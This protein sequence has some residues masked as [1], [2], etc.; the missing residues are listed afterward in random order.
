MTIIQKFT[1]SAKEFVLRF[2]LQVILSAAIA[3]V[4]IY[5]VNSSNYFPELQKTLGIIGGLSVAFSWSL[6]VNLLAERHQLSRRNSFFVQLIPIAVAAI[7]FW[8][9]SEE[10]FYIN[11]FNLRV[12]VVAV[13]GIIFAITI[14]FITTKR[15]DVWDVF[16]LIV[17]RLVISVLFGA[18]LYVGLAICLSAYGLLISHINGHIFGYLAASIGA[19][20]IPTYFLFGMP[21]VWEQVEFDYTK[22]E[23]I[24]IGTILFPVFLCSYIILYIYLA[25][26]VATW[27][28]PNG[29]VAS[30]IV[31]FSVFGTVVAVMG[32]RIF[33]ESESKL[34][35][36][37]PRIFQIATLPM[38]VVLAIAIKFRVAEY[39]LTASRYAVIAF[40][41]WL[42]IT[43]IYNSLK[44]EIRLKFML[45]FAGC[46]A[47]FA[48]VG[49]YNMATTSVK[50]QYQRAILLFEKHKIVQRGIFVELTA[51]DTFSAE[52]IKQLRSQLDYVLENGGRH[53]F[54]DAM[55]HVRQDDIPRTVDDMLAWY[56]IEVDSDMITSIQSD[57]YLPGDTVLDIS[58]FD[59]MTELNSYIFA[60]D[61]VIKK[62][63]P[64]GALTV[65]NIGQQVLVEIDGHKINLSYEKIVDDTLKKSSHLVPY[66]DLTIEGWS[67]GY[68]AKIIITNLDFEPVGGGLRKFKNMTAVLLLKKDQ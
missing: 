17:R 30:W 1:E 25:K 15:S 41:V 57:M 19:F 42:L 32:R 46:I 45:I 23:R 36:L 7:A 13:V 55:P 52:E 28:W 64:I 59:Y 20:F 67:E 35:Q 9:F 24:L 39:G 16:G 61:G 22:F 40:G 5:M 4:L 33:A 47:L 34:V 27:E 48:A 50:N 29:E 18:V 2:G 44:K 54:F 10:L 12:G 8:N 68:R 58:G 38:I 31:G 6:F 60:V 53:L 37:F 21:K 63:T 66:T 51:A 3:G 11:I 62:N 49:P 65:S 43:A 26:I 56:K 14:P